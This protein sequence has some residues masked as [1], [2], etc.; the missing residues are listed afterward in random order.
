MKG[1]KICADLVY[2]Y[3]EMGFL[4]A[5]KAP[6]GASF[7]SASTAFYIVVTGICARRL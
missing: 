1:E 4:A 6:G 3:F 2:V 5:K 7:L